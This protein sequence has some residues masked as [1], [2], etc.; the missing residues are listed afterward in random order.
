MHYATDWVVSN[1]IIYAKCTVRVKKIKHYLARLQQR[2]NNYNNKTTP[3]HLS[4]YN[5]HRLIKRNDRPSKSTELNK[6]SQYRT[7]ITHIPEDYNLYTTNKNSY[8]QPNNNNNNNITTTQNI[9]RNN[10]NIYKSH[11]VFH[12]IHCKF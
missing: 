2:Q 11:L 10:I 12:L 8:Q 6:K 1:D 5:K 3:T 9:Y 7:A 4:N